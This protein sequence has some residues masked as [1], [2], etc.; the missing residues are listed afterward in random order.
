MNV[1]RHKKRRQATRPLE[2]P[3]PTAQPI[4]AWIGSVAGYSFITAIIL[5]TSLYEFI[6]N[7]QR[8]SD[9][10]LILW[11]ALTY[12][13]IGQRPVTSYAILGMIVLVWLLASIVA[14][15]EMS[16]SRMFKGSDRPAGLALYASL[17]MGAALVFGVGLA[18]LLGVLTRI[19]VTRIEDTV[20]V[21]DRVAGIF[22]Y[23]YMGVFLLI[24]LAGLAFVAEYKHLP[25]TWS[26]NGWGL[27]ALVPAILVTYFWINFSNLDSIRADIVYKQ[28]DS[29]DKQGQQDAAIAHYKHAIELA[30]N[31]DFYYLFLGK[32]FLDKASVT[33]AAPTS[34]FNDQTQLE[35]IL[36][37][38]PQQTAILG[39]TDLLQAARAV[40]TRAREINPLNTDHSANLARLYQSWANLA[41]DP[42]Q[43][44]QLAEQSS[45]YYAQATSLS[46]HNAVLWDE[47]ARGDLLLRNDPD[48]A[49]QK[50]QESLK[51]DTEF[52]QTYAYLG[53]VY[54]TKKDY[55][56][57]IPAYQKLLALQPNAV[58]AQAAL[59][60]IYAQ[61]NKI[62]EAI[63]ANQ[64][65]IEMAPTSPNVWDAH[66]NLAL[67]YAQ[68]GNL[69]SAINE[70]QIAASTAPTDTQPQLIAF[71]SQLRSQMDAAT[72]PPTSP[73]TATSPMTP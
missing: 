48:A 32:V 12:L 59:A 31:E 29:W 5:S 19:Q 15:S 28:G 7:V 20:M 63:Q 16:R 45:Q 17:S 55:D 73:V 51:L 47:W 30:P 53:E 50:L 40:L 72:Q 34:L 27:I 9:P 41:T 60:Y 66:K 65:L 62:P 1:P 57:A 6:Q 70:A 43:K 24:L 56:N 11:R 13:S 67:L 10:T 69:P 18:G 71:V 58:Q 64:N 4:P 44:A 2:R 21:A 36:N 35:G 3:T 23:Y 68:T 25:A 38:N 39:R 8:L 22:N 14:V 37:L 49:L 46:P 52:D 26:T 33:N 54:M 61:Q 42:A